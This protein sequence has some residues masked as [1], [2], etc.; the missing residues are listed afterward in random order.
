VTAAVLGNWEIKEN[1]EKLNT[2]A[3]GAGVLDPLFAEYRERCKKV[4][5]RVHHLMPGVKVLI[6]QDVWFNWPEPQPNEFEDSW[7]V[8]KDGKRYSELWRGQYKPSPGI[9]PTATNRYGKAFRN[10][11]TQV[12][13]DLGVDGFY[14]DDSNGPGV[15]KDPITYNAWDGC[16]AI[17]DPKTFAIQHKVGYLSL[18]ANDYH[19]K[20][21]DE[22][23]AEGV[24]LLA[25]FEPYTFSFNR[26]TW[27]RFSESDNVKNTFTTHLYA[28]IA[29][30]YHFEAYSV[31][32]LRDRLDVGALYCVTGPGDKLGIVNK[33]FP[34][35]PTAL[36]A[37]WIEGEERIVTDRSGKY[38]WDKQS[39]RAR[40][41]R[42]RADGTPVEADP[43]WQ[44]LQGLVAVEVPERGIAILER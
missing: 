42:Y 2:L 5:E 20:L 25:N 16:S 6:Y 13:R 18:L 28:P 26:D 11:L 12:R 23:K 3:F 31:K 15:L 19:R 33:F 14:F 40:L 7:I 22:L 17:L 36:H 44:E 32:E 27:P 29:F 1:G 37:G 41:W 43:P 34:I 35:T 4:A 9:F 10:M 30:S 39:Y 38:G 21:F 8:L 24:P